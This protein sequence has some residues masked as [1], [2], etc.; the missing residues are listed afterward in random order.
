MTRNKG[1][2]IQWIIFETLLGGEHTGHLSVSPLAPHLLFHPTE[3]S[4]ATCPPV[5]P[6]PNP[7]ALNGS[8]PTCSA[9]SPSLTSPIISIMHST[10]MLGRLVQQCLGLSS[11]EKGP[12][13]FYFHFARCHVY[14]QHCI[15]SKS[16]LKVDFLCVQV[17]K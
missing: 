14:A 16:R 13:H 3:L 1:N 15:N 17:I 8:F 7:S 11:S 2:Y 9:H 10:A 12:C 6:A 4:G 5:V